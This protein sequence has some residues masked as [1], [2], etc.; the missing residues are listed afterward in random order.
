MAGPA[1]LGLNLGVLMPVRKRHRWYAARTLTAAAG[2]CL[3]VGCAWAMQNAPA[4]DEKPAP[5]PTKV[6]QR[7]TELTLKDGQ[8]V[9]GILISQD[10]ESIILN[11][12]GVNTTFAMNQV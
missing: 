5:A 12:Q 9:T 2:I 4:P 8:K 1:I 11:I 3:A 7:E 10:A 6:E